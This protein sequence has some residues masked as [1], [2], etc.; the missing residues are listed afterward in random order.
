MQ[1]PLISPLAMQRD[2]LF[3]SGRRNRFQRL[4]EYAERRAKIFT[5]AQAKNKKPEPVVTSS[6]AGR[7][8]PRS[9]LEASFP[10]HAPRWG[11]GLASRRQANAVALDTRH[12][13]DENASRFKSRLLSF[14]LTNDE[15]SEEIQMSE[16]RTLIFGKDAEIWY[17]YTP[18]CLEATFAATNND[19]SS[20]RP[21]K[22]TKLH[23]DESSTSSSSKPP[24][25]LRNDSDRCCILRLEPADAETSSAPIRNVYHSTDS[26][27][28]MP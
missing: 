17:K 10:V 16:R 21:T 1:F 27:Q 24:A 13:E 28:R 7:K 25:P 19:E 2:R 11:F 15:S 8:R 14:S 12:E 18:D 5:G 9:M 20:E 6:L 23:L 22:R 3:K 4:F 26:S